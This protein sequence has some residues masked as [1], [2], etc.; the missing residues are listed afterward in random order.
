[1]LWDG[2]A[3]SLRGGGIFRACLVTDPARLIDPALYHAITTVQVRDGRMQ[4][5]TFMVPFGKADPVFT[6]WLETRAVPGSA[7]AGNRVVLCKLPTPC[8]PARRQ[9]MSDVKRS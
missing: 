5:W 7:R 4:Y 2:I 8:S 6:A 3:A 1:M 9:P